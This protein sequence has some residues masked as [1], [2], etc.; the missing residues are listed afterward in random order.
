MD[1]GDV[2]D[3]ATPKKSPAQATSHTIP[4]SFLA[5]DILKHLCRELDRDKVE[6]EF[7][8]KVNADLNLLDKSF[9]SKLYVI[10]MLSNSVILEKNRL[11]GSVTSKR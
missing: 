10:Q 6:A 8:I 4:S 11:G 7:S 9:L 1:T 3:S 2:Y 5:P